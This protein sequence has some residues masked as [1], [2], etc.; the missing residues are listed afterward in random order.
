MF[1]N[2]VENI[3]KKEGLIDVAKCG[4]A[5]QS[6]YS[7][8]SHANDAI[9]PLLNLEDQD[10]AFHTDKQKNP[11]WQIEFEETVKLDYIIINNRKGKSFEKKASKISVVVINEKEEEIIIHSGQVFF[12]SFPESLPLILPLQAQISIK[13]IKIELKDFNYLHLKNIYCLKRVSLQESSGGLIY[14][15][16][17]IDGLGERLRALLHAVTLANENQGQFYFSWLHSKDE[18]HSTSNVNRIFSDSFVAK[19]YMDRDKIDSLNTITLNESKGMS[20]E[21]LKCYDGILVGQ[22][23]RSLSEAFNSILFSDEVTVAKQDAL[24]IQLP[25]NVVAVHLRAGDIVYGKHR[26]SNR[27]YSKIN[28]IYILDRM[29]LKLREEGKEVIVFGQNHNF[30]NYISKKYNL[31]FSSDLNSEHYIGVQAAIFDIVLMSRCNN[32]FA[33]ESGFAIISSLIGKA[34]V[35]ESY[36]RFFSK[37]DVIDEFNKSILENGIL[38]SEVVDPLLKALSISQFLDSYQVYLPIERKLELVEKC[39]ALD[40][41]NSYYKLLQS[42][43][44]YQSDN[45]EKADVVL[46]NELNNNSEYNIIWLAKNLDWR[47]RTVLLQYIETFKDAKERGSEVAAIIV[48]LHQYYYEKSIN[49]KLYKE[50][51][52]NTSIGSSLDIEVLQ[53]KFNKLVL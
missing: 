50:T 19:H 16:N 24:D 52:S 3:C 33:R 38:N 11:W 27:Y 46:L 2:F 25:Q 17:R 9:R 6:S 48:F 8:W 15:A 22:G 47:K 45:M 44:L 26:Y 14:F 21:Q 29:L 20:Y 30:C 31:I 12:G 35:I 51:L 43:F 41:Q 28:P 5:N 10:Y 1:E 39:I 37:E 32:I 13:K 42:V 36:D 49:H 53:K 4:T 18:F 40:C 7:K 34:E 23:H